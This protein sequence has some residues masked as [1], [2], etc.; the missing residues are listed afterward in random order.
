MINIKIDSRKIKKGDTFVAIPG[1]TVDGHDFV[2]KAYENGAIKAIVN[3]KVD[4]DIEQ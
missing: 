2:K 1:A 3:H 4:C